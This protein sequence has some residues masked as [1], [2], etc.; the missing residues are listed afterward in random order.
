MDTINSSLK[1]W[2]VAGSFRISR[3][4]V[5]EVHV[6]VATVTKNGHTGRGECRPYQRYGESPKSVCAQIDGLREGLS[7]LTLDSLQSRLPAGAARNAVDCALWDLKA[8]TERRS[9]SDLLGLPAP[10]ARKTA[11]TLSLDSPDNMAKA[12]RKARGHSVLKIKVGATDGL[13][14]ALAVMNARPD[15]ELIIDANEALDGESLSRFQSTLAGW[16][17]LMIEQPMPAGSAMPSGVST[18]L[19][20]MCA[21]EALHTSGDLEMLWAQGFRA[22]NI[23]M[24]KAGGLTEGLALARAA[25]AKGFVIMLG[26]MVGSSLAMAPAMILESFADVVDL[27]GALLLARDHSGGLRY[28]DGKVWP[29]PRTLWG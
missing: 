16:P 18:T 28:D 19:P 6:V 29:A 20:I 7:S 8:K 3:S 14:S 22:V 2:P 13:K 26:C 25:K 15:A 4:S 23:K 17:V 10:R 12:A 9:V 24:D 5:T 11:F 1:I 27:D 21:D